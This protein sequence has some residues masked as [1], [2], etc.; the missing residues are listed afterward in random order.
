MARYRFTSRINQW[1]DGKEVD[2]DKS[3]L[4]LVTD[5]HRTSQILAPKLTRSLVKSGRIVRKG[6][7]HYAVRYGD[8]QVPYA[9]RRHYENRK[10]PQTLRYL[11]RAGDAAS[12]NIKRYLR[13]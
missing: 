13:V 6:L 10:N 3:M 2:F 11:E 9:R 12:R 5:V 7:A 4:A 8:R 1:V